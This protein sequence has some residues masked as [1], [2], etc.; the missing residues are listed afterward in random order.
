MQKRIYITPEKRWF[1][2]TRTETELTGFEDVLTQAITDFNLITPA[3]TENTFLG[4]NAGRIIAIRLLPTLPVVC[5]WYVEIGLPD[6]YDIDHDTPVFL[7]SWSIS[8]ANTP[9]RVNKEFQ[10]DL[11]DPYEM[12]FIQSSSTQGEDMH[13]TFVA[14]NM[15][16]GNIKHPLI[17][18]VYDTGNLC[19]GSVRLPPFEFRKGFEHRINEVLSI[20]CE[21]RWNSDLNILEFDSDAIRNWFA[22]D[23]ETCEMVGNRSLEEFEHQTFDLHM[24]RPWEHE[25]LMSLVTLLGGEVPDNA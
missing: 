10:Y 20:W 24:A 6:D 17:P 16:N 23:T 8:G 5:D 15:Q 1:L 2:E 18:N 22:F 4:F 12:A 13:F 25:L 7:P 14:V 19:F 21:G 9:L 11:P 3:A